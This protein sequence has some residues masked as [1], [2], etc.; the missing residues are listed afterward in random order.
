[1]GATY[2]Y[3]SETTDRKAP[4]EIIEAAWLRIMPVIDL[5]GKS[6]A[7]PQGKWE[8]TSWTQRYK[9]NTPS[10]DGALAVHHILDSELEGMPPSS[11]FKL[12]DDCEFLIGHSID[13]DCEAMR[14]PQPN[15]KRI[16]TNAMARWVWP[17]ATGYSQTALIYRISGRTD[18]TRRVVQAAHGALADAC[19]CVTILNSILALRPEIKTWPQLWEFSEECR[20]PRT[21]PHKRYEGV[22]LED[23]DYGYIRWA[24]DQEWLDPYF[25][26]GLERVVSKRLDELPF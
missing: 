25:R 13:H 12:P 8:F 4:M 16:C 20:I 1:M 22:P 7:I 18:D 10:T 2:V 14:T 6:D 23:L 24:L 5:M 26:K 11:E 17:E 9:P 21:C 3:D 15:V 19:M